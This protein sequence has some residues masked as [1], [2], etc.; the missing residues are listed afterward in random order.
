MTGTPYRRHPA[1]GQCAGTLACALCLYSSP[2]SPNEK[3]VVGMRPILMHIRINPIPHSA[4]RTRMSLFFSFDGVDGVGKSTQL[5][6]F[7]EWLE[8]EGH[9]VTACRDPGGTRLGEAIRQLLLHDEGVAIGARSEMLLYMASRAQLVNEV[10]E[11]ELSRGKVVVSDRFLL[12]NVVYQGH[13]GQLPPDSLWQVGDVATDGLRPDCTFLLDMPAERAMQRITGT[14]DKMESRGV[15][16]LNRVRRG[17]LEE[18]DAAGGC[19]VLIDADRDP[20]AI[21]ADIRSAA[22]PYLRRKGG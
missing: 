13:A 5:E 17:F 4:F 2:R 21:Q 10:I 22:A 9:S 18:A 12:A 20:M 16:F 15:D 19:I 3:A 7:C 6:Q 11:P 8:H 1:A 14:P